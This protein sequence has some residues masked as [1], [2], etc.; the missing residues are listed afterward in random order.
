M[1]KSKFAFISI[2]FTRVVTWPSKIRCIP[3]TG[4]TESTTGPTVSLLPDQ[5]N[6]SVKMVEALIWDLE[7]VLTYFYPISNRLPLQKLPRQHDLQPFWEDQSTIMGIFLSFVETTMNFNHVKWG[8]QWSNTNW[9]SC[10]RGVSNN[11]QGINLDGHQFNLWGIDNNQSRPI[12][13]LSKPNTKI[14]SLLSD[15]SVKTP[16]GHFLNKKKTSDNRPRDFRDYCRY[17]YRIFFHRILYI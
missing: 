15:H 10:H 9:T 2:S 8:H 11:Q 3:I 14:I 6:L 5:L 12:H 13:H 16:L 17:R 4:P 7:T 1:T